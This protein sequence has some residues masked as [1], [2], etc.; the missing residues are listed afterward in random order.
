[1]LWI[2]DEQSFRVKLYIYALEQKREYSFF[3]HSYLSAMEKNTSSV[4]E[5]KPFL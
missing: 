5:D 3:T 2:E 4:Y 1:M